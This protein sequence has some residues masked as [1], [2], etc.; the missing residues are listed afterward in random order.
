MTIFESALFTFFLSLR[1]LP[2]TNIILLATVEITSA[3]FQLKLNDFKLNLV[4]VGKATTV[5]V[6]SKKL[7]RKASMCN[8]KMKRVKN[9]FH[10]NV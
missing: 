9:E 1:T 2:K 8:Y 5:A 6:T 4:I 10:S 3:A 7:I